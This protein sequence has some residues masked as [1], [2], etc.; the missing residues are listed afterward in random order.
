[1]TLMKTKVKLRLWPAIFVAAIVLAA[2]AGNIS[3]ASLADTNQFVIASMEEAANGKLAEW[4][5]FVGWDTLNKQP[6]WDGFSS[7]APFPIH[8]AVTKAMREIKQANP[9]LKL[10]IESV[11]VKP[12]TAETKEDEAKGVTSIWYYF[13][14]LVPVDEAVYDD[15]EKAGKVATLSRVVLMDGTV[16]SADLKKRERKN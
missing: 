1:M 10:K 5:W 16:I 11:M 8:E 7:A 6:H 4:E 3:S 13:V 9:D 2:L 14:Q 12:A 15:V